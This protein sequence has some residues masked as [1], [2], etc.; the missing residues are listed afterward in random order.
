MSLIHCPAEGCDYWISDGGYTVSYLMEL[1][2]HVEKAHA[3]L[4][5]RLKR[6]DGGIV[7][8]M[9]SIALARP[10]EEAER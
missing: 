10:V 7:D 2:K 3:D 1:K 6:R 8:E 5:V 4:P 9:V